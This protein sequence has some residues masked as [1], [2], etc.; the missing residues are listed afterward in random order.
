MGGG[1]EEE[2]MG[3]VDGRSIT[4]IADVLAINNLVSALGRYS[5]NTVSFG[6]HNASLA[7]IKAAFSGLSFRSPD[8]GC[9]YVCAN[10][11]A[12]ADPRSFF[13]GRYMAH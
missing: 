3:T 10:F 12:F 8:L 1:G 13:F 9:Y 4:A 6:S 5:A 7:D 2:V 11:G